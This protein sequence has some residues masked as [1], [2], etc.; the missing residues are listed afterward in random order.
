LRRDSTVAV[1]EPP[2][3]KLAHVVGLSRHLDLRL[4]ETLKAY[5]YR[6]ARGY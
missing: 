5:V 3:G 2:T 4:V 1:G 6:V